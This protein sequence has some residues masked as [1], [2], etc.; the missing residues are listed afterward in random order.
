MKMTHGRGLQYLLLDLFSPVPPLLSSLHVHHSV[1]EKIGLSLNF[2][3][4]AWVK[5]KCCTG[6]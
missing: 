5:C 4:S 2:H 3:A 1:K 6:L